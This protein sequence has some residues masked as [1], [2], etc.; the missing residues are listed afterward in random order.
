MLLI[1]HVLNQHFR[2]NLNLKY[3]SVKLL[4]CLYN[5]CCNIV[6]KLFSW[7]PLRLWITSKNFTINHKN[8][9]HQKAQ[10]KNVHKKNIYGRYQTCKYFIFFFLFLVPNGTW[11]FHH[12]YQ[13][14]QT[15]WCIKLLTV[16]SANASVNYP[17]AFTLLQLSVLKALS[18]DGALGS[19]LI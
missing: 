7:T 2:P 14:I 16:I 10:I 8:W 12:I 17:I 3:S 11:S 13:E 9:Y 5:P 1:I 19:H 15:I 6:F 4:S 18:L